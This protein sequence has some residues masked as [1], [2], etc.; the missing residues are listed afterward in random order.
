MSK[1]HHRKI[2]EFRTLKYGYL[3]LLNIPSLYPYFK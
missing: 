1:Y 3:K 2:A